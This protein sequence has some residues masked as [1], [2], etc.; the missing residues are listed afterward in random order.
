MALKFKL[1]DRLNLFLNEDN[2]YL[3][4]SNNP[5]YHMIKYQL[6][7]GC[8]CS[9]NQWNT[10]WTRIKYNSQFY[11]IIGNQFNE[12]NNITEILIYLLTAP[13][14]QQSDLCNLYAKIK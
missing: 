14:I 12:L 6:G 7:G 4:M 3:I 1:A 10:I 11:Y 8:V 9:S 2:I 5:F 13:F